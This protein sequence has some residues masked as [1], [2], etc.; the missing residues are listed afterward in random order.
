MP[1]L[2][3]V[4]P[5]WLYWGTLIVFPLVAWYFVARQRKSGV[6]RRPSLFIA[7]L[8]W[9]CSGFVGLHRFYLRSAWGLV[10]VPVFLAFCMS[11]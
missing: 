1:S 4:L 2:N 11:M 10:F 6:S 8:F 7:C 3:F 5:H 9:V